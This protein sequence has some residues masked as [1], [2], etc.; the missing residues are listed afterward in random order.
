MRIMSRLP[1]ALAVLGVLA[2]LGGAARAAGERDWI[3]WNTTDGPAI[4]RWETRWFHLGERGPEI[5]A[6]R[7]E[8]MASDGTRVW[9]LVTQRQAVPLRSCEC[10][11]GLEAPG[12]HETG[13]STAWSLVA[14]DLIDGSE[15][16]VIPPESGFIG[17]D[18]AESLV[19]VGSAGAHVFASRTRGATGCGSDTK[20]LREFT[21]FD[22]ARRARDRR[23]AADRLPIALVSDAAA[24]LANRFTACETGFQKSSDEVRRDMGLD[25]WSLRVQAKAALRP[26]EGVRDGG[27]LRIR[28]TFSAEA[29]YLACRE[30]RLAVDLE[31]GTMAEAGSLGLASPPPDVIDTALATGQEEGTIVG[32]AALAVPDR[33]DRDK[34]IARFKSAPSHVSVQASEAAIKRLTAELRAADG[35]ERS[36]GG[37]QAGAIQAFGEALAFDP[38]LASAW[39]GRGRAKLLAGD[40]AGAKADLEKAFLFI[41]DTDTQAAVWYDLGQVAERMGDRKQAREAYRSA[42]AIRPCSLIDDALGRLP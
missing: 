41:R 12:C 35:R 16:V 31:S 32:F 20:P 8:P 18:P 21:T 14:V 40:L 17:A 29:E 6:K 26:P 1:V 36:R 3:L 38:E 30:A 2:G 28:W 22:L 10:D 11:A 33:A 4:G 27:H 5:L 19:L 25:G 42:A 39:A 23:F 24:A 9:S 34:L 13:T 15:T 37:D 7:A